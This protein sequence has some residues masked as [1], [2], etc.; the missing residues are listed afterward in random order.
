MTRDQVLKVLA[1]GL[2]QWGPY[3]VTLDGSG[4]LVT[5][6]T[7]QDTQEAKN[8][9]SGRSK[10]VTGQAQRN[11]G[12]RHPCPGGCGL[13]LKAISHGSHFRICPGM[14]RGADGTWVPKATLA[15]GGPVVVK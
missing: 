13:S 3:Q 11:T 14:V 2:T 12:R 9:R 6:E 8:G 10:R 1:Q 4:A 7:T 5:R 15:P